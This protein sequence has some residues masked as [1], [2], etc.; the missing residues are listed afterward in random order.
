MASSRY[1]TVQNGT[2]RYTTYRKEVQIEEKQQAKNQSGFVTIRY[3]TGRYST[4][5]DI[6][7]RGTNRRKAKIVIKAKNQ[8]GLV[9]IRYGT[10]RYSTVQDI[11]KRGTNRRKAT[12]KKSERPRHGTIQYRT[13]QHG[14]RHTDKRYK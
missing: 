4:I 6:Q 10:E 11:Q 9:T 13:V 7:T 12:S 14:T 3:S 5:Q 2:A 8:S 1:G